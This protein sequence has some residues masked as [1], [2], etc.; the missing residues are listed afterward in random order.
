[1][2]YRASP[3]PIPNNADTPVFFTL[4]HWDTHEFFK[5]DTNP[6]KLLIPNGLDGLYLIGASMQ[7]SA[8]GLGM[9]RSMRVRQNG[10]FDI[11]YDRS[12]DNV[13]AIPQQGTTVQRLKNNDYL[14]MYVV[15]NSGLAT[16]DIQAVD[17]Y[18]PIMWCVRLGS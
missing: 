16:L 10:A 12:T 1:M 2:C 18:S 7:W 5:P 6:T 17:R 9:N 11:L 4:D 3:Y 15:H 13:D 14:E 8:G